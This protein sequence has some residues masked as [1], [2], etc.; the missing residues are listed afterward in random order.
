MQYNGRKFVVNQ[1]IKGLYFYDDINSYE[2]PLEKPFWG[3][4]C[5]ENTYQCLS[6]PKKIQIIYLSP[7]KSRWQWFELLEV[8]FR[9]R[10][11]SLWPLVHNVLVIHDLRTN[12]ELHAN[13]NGEI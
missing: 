10:S 8:F 6:H 3:A 13:G 7:I 1:Y 4:L 5:L 12:R 2:K 9:W 11:K